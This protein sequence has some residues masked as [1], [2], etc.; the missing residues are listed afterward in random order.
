VRSGED[1]VKA[2]ASG[3]NFVLLGRPFL[4]AMAADGAR[5]VSS[6]LDS[7]TSD[8]A[9]ALAQVGLKRVEDINEAILASMSARKP[10]GAK[11]ILLRGSGA[12]S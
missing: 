10:G 4:Y 6:F 7:L 12:G 8:V 5:G 2:L 3:A 11:P 1:V 9:I